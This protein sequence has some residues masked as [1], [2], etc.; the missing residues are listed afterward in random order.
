[1]ENLAAHSSQES[2][3]CEDSTALVKRDWLMSDLHSSDALDNKNDPNIG[4]I[5]YVIIRCL[6]TETNTAIIEHLEDT[7]KTI[8]DTEKQLENRIE[9]EKFLNLFYDH[10]IHWLT[11]PFHEKFRHLKLPMIQTPSRCVTS[12]LSASAGQAIIELLCLCV[13][14]H[15]YK[16]KY[17]IMRNNLLSTC[18][19]I[20]DRKER[21]LYLSVMKLLRTVITTKEDFYLRHIVKGD[22]LK[23]IFHLLEKNAS[24]DN[25]ITS[26]IVE[27]VEF[28][29]TENIRI[30]V[31]YIMDKYSHCFE[32]LTHVDV[33][34]RIVL[35]HEQNQSYDNENGMNETSESVD[36][37]G[38]KNKQFVE[39]EKEEAYWDDDDDDDDTS[40][41]SSVIKRIPSSKSQNQSQPVRTNPLSLL[42]ECYGDFDDDDDERRPPLEV[43]SNGS[44]SSL[45]NMEIKSTDSTDN[46][47]MNAVMLS[48]DSDDSMKDSMSVDDG[49]DPPLPP[50]RSKYEVDDTPVSAFFKGKN[51]DT[52]QINGS[53][54]ASRSPSMENRNPSSSENS[55]RASTAQNNS[56]QEKFRFAI[57]VKRPTKN[58][59]VR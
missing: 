46:G 33:Y 49:D 7:L 11:V 6:V 25:L 28:I 53:S 3:D 8:L 34:D 51:I 42:S 36:Y 44:A 1:V 38:S 45:E 20:L 52:K 26:T 29:R 31:T 39:L 43:K 13:R 16:M 19:S 22:L 23:E 55:S 47:T 32:N 37:R 50:L 4:S 30:L 59:S 41:H 15:A 14:N 12:S 54:S 5:L 21:H 40:D 10:Y 2:T 27:L 58:D 9:M 18:V 57:A 56:K 17:F 35:R 24:K 48:M